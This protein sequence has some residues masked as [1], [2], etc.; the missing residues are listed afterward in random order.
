[1]KGTLKKNDFPQT[2]TDNLSKEY[3]STNSNSEKNE[4][5]LEFNKENRFQ[6]YFFLS[7]TIISII[8]TFFMIF[9]FDNYWGKI[10]M[11]KPEGY[12]IPKIADLKFLLFVTPVIIAIKCFFEYGPP[13]KLMYIF[14]SKKYKDPSNDNFKLGKVYKRKLATALFKLIYYTISVIIGHFVLKDINFFDWKLGGNGDIDKLNAGGYPQWVFWEKPD[15]FNYYYL[16]GLSFVCTDLIWL[17][18]IYEYSTDFYLMLCHHVITI[19]LVAFS[20]LSNISNVGCLVFYLHDITDIF[21][22]IVRIVINTDYNECVKIPPCIAL[23]LSKIYLRIYCLVLIIIK[24]S[25]SMM[26]ENLYVKILGNFL[27]MLVI[28]HSFWIVQIIK[29]F[30]HWS[31]VDVGKVIKKNK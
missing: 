19:T 13:L 10:I 28:M 16:T 26:A 5:E 12:Q 22:Y 25:E 8:G 29:R 30:W 15:Y 3:Y 23:L 1:M 6:D 27:W 9:S 2:C 21:V 31:I 20:Y 17:L 7:L 4:K 11:F 24:L 18:F 14:L